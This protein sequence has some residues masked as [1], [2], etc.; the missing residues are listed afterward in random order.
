M[1]RL[2]ALEPFRPPHLRRLCRGRPANFLVE[3]LHRPR[4]STI[5]GTHR[6]SGCSQDGAW[7]VVDNRLGDGMHDRAH[8]QQR[9]QRAVNCPTF[10][11]PPRLSVGGTMERR[12]SARMAP[13]VTARRICTA[14]VAIDVTLD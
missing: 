10:P 6:G 7:R 11:R 3:L 9:L 14:P 1:H 13:L 8:E 2:P 12:R 4:P 5:T